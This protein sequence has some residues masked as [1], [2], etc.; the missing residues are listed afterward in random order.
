VCT[1]IVI[2]GLCYLLTQ[3]LTNY[4]VTHRLH[5]G[6]RVIVEFDIGFYMITAAG[7]VSVIAVGSTLMH[8]HSPSSSASRGWS[9]D[10]LLEST[11]TRRDRQPADA[12]A[13]LLILAAGACAPESRAPPPYRP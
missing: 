4:Y 5:D 13:R 3:Q 9:H 1:C 10:T 12:D 2:T 8:V 11:N 6:S 7:A